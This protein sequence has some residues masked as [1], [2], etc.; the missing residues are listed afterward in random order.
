MTS[1]IGSEEFNTEAQKIGFNV[2]E[3]EEEKILSDYTASKEK[4]L[5]QLP[6]FFAP[7]F[8][9]RIDKTIVFNPLDK[10]VLKSIVVL[11]MNEL[12]ERMEEIN[13]D[14]SYDPK[15]VAHIV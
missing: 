13:I 4:V 11:Q 3:A 6:D 2:S 12:V 5:K 14:F 10:K 7:E 9:N 15:M 1:N 8:L